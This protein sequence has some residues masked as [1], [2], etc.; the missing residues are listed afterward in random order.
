LVPT[1]GN[2]LFYWGFKFAVNRKRLRKAALR[3]PFLL[4]TSSRSNPII[5]P[6]GD[7]NDAF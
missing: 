6:H 7:V 1:V 4:P 2:W 5:N 3:E